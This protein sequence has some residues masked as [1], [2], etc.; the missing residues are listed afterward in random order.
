MKHLYLEH[1][2][3]ALACALMLAL[4][5][6]TV[7]AAT[8]GSTPGGIRYASG[9]VSNEEQ[10]AM[11]ARFAQYT[12]RVATAAKGSGAYMAG[13][14]ARIIDSSGRLVLEHV[15]DGPWLL[16]NLP[17]GRYRIELRSGAEGAAGAQVQR[18]DVTVGA[19]GMTDVTVHFDA[20]GEPGPRPA[21]SAARQP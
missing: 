17:A 19:R 10:D 6:D 15:L 13:V 1:P 8:D 3:R 12:L 14:R 5:A 7:G 18:R 2:A 9:G 16:V 11:R 20:A 4:A 21:A